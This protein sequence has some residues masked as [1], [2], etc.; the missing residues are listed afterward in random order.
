[1]NKKKLLIR[2]GVAGAIIPII[3][4][5]IAYST[6]TIMSGWNI[7]VF[8]I[9]WISYFMS[10]ALWS[11]GGAFDVIFT[12]LVI[13]AL[14]MGYY[15]LLGWLFWQGKTRN[16]LFYLSM[17]TVASLAWSYIYLRSW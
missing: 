17:P 11:V 8:G 5:V 1:M 2:C 15:V 12:C 3:L 10:M 4:F 7:Y 13:L 14:N 6:E 9:F 16:K